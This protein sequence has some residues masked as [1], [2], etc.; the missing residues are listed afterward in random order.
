MLE[1]QHSKW[2][3][4]RR[5]HAG[6]HPARPCVKPRDGRTVNTRRYAAVEVGNGTVARQLGGSR[7]QLK[8][9]DG[10]W[11]SADGTWWFH[12]EV[13]VPNRSVDDLVKALGGDT[14]NSKSQVSKIC[15]GLDEQIATFRD[16]Q[17]N[18]SVFPYVF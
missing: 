12:L 1:P 13:P 18:H 3:G 7:P 5:L 2:G 16:R 10:A 15:A 8:R 9:A 6:R 11:N 14:G 4:T 17:L